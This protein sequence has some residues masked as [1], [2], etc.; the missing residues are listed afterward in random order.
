VIITAIPVVIATVGLA[1]T[2]IV[3]IRSTVT[4][5]VAAAAV[6]V[7]V[8]RRSWSSSILRVPQ[9]HALAVHT[10]SWYAWCRWN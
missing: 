9:G 2:V 1:V 5:V 7:V 6:L 4:V 10:H 3:S 8:C